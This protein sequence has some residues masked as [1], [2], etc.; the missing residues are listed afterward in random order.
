MDPPPINNDS[1][2]FTVYAMPDATLPVPE[3]VAGWSFVRTMDEYLRENAL[4]AAEYRGTSDAVP[5]EV[6]E[7][8]LPP[9]FDLPCPTEGEQPENCLT[10]D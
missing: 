6:T 1:Y 4:A 8:T 9:V 10:A 7:G 3:V 2:S 5:S